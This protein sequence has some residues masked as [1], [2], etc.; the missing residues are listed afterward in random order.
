MAFDART[1]ST[2][3][4]T[5]VVVSSIPSY[6]STF[7]PRLNKW[8]KELDDT[9]VATLVNLRNDDSNSAREASGLVTDYGNGIGLWYPSFDAPEKLKAIA[10]L[11]EIAL[12]HDGKINTILDQ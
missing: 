10:M 7:Q 5:P 6:V 4:S 9:S 2:D 1:Y 3:H 8:S 12:F 11:T